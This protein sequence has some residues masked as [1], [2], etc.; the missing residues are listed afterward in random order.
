M[1]D[2]QPIWTPSA[3]SAAAAPMAAFM[4]SCNSKYGMEMHCYAD[5]HAWSTDNREEFWSEVWD[6]CNVKGERG[7]RALVDVGEMREAQFFP[8]ARLNFAENLL[9]SASSADAIVFRGE[10]K[11]ADRWSWDRLRAAVSQL[12]QAYTAMGIGEGDCIAAM[13]PNMPETVACMLAA[14]SI[15]A[16]WSSC[17]PDF[18][19]QGVLD[20]FS[21]IGPKLFVACDAYWYGGKKQDL[22]EKVPAIAARLGAPSVI[23]HYAGDAKDVARKIADSRTLEDFIAPYRAE[24]PTFTRL[25]FSHPLY[26]LFSSGTTGV[27]KCIVHS[28]GGT[29]LQHLKEH[30]LHC[31]LQLGEKLFYFTTCGWMMWNWLVSGLASGATLCLYDGSPF[32]P[33]AK[34]LFEYAEAEHF[35]IFGTSAK[36][37]DAL[38]VSGLKPATHDLA[39][40][41]LIAST[42][43]PL[44][45]DSFSFVH[46]CIKED[47][48]LASIAGGTDIIS[49][50]VLG[51]PLQPVWRGEIQGAGLGL[52]VDVWDDAGRPI[53]HGKGELVCAKAF[54]SMPIMFWNDPNGAKY[55]AA[56]FERF[57]K[58]WCHGDF[59]EWT[60]HGGMVIHGRSDA[61]LNPGGVRIGTAEIYNQIENMEEVVEAL[62]IGQ[63][64]QGDERII[65]F[66]RLASG[67]A[68]DDE[69]ILQMKARIRHQASPRH[70]PAKII[71]VND[72]PRTRSGKVVELAVREVVHGR[73]VRN[74]EALSNP[75]ALALFT[76]LEALST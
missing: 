3:S 33:D 66:V 16:I 20:R 1:N 60:E 26:V 5:L 43:S 63:E 36:Y 11:A 8:D 24:A 6:F 58:V 62:C 7:A 9:A 19:E 30:R 56:Y 34:V 55:R 69:L 13:M 47:V 65:L 46:E 73:T 49:C 71:A 64:W 25:P 76:G 18:G 15:G 51:N 59:A 61:T 2:T 35:A 17:S 48:H 74:R 29:L 32:A 21:Q 44:S 72:I 75:E 70:V 40:L 54:P 39:S 68:L 38:R 67:I 31:G 12:Q 22:S 23:V 14:A 45:P 57:D 28:A 50:F 53:R 52:A 4:E 27:P 41:R 10:D 42:G 37:I